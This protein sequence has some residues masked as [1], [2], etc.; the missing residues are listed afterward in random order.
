MKVDCG[1]NFGTGYP[2]LREGLVCQTCGSKNRDRLMMLASRELLATSRKTIFFGALSGWARWAKDSHP[3]RLVFCEYLGDEVPRGAEVTIE[4]QSV[5][6]QDLTR[7]TFESESADLILHQDVLEH[8]PDYKTAL[9]E[10]FRVLR[11]GA[12]TIF[13]A[14][15]F[16]EMDDTFVRATVG[17]DGAITH[18]AAEE[19]H[20]DPLVPEGILTFY[21]FGWSLMDDMRSAGFVDASLGLLYRPDL[22]LVSNG[23]P[24][25]ALNMMPVFISA[26]KPEAR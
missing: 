3:H 14:P 23:C 24:F 19:R 1:S 25:P 5:F 18:L 13:T 26:T 7:M 21:N 20:G 8:I 10:T 22:G 16:H 2:N 6:N 4:G 17:T 9:Q 11:P 12:K 15:F